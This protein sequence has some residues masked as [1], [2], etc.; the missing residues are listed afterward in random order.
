MRIELYGVHADNS[1]MRRDRTGRNEV[2]RRLIGSR[3]HGIST[4]ILALVVVAWSTIV[5]V[6]TP[7]SVAAAP[8]SRV[9]IAQVGGQ[10][11][12]GR[13]IVQFKSERGL[14]SRVA[15]ERTHGTEI[16][17]EWTS[18]L[19]GF[20]G[21]LSPAALTR[22]QS[23]PEV[24]RIEPDQVITTDTY[25]PSPPS[26]GLDRIDQ[27][28]LPLT[29]SY[30]YVSTGSGVTAY[31]VDTG[32]RSTHTEFTGRVGAGFVS[33]LFSPPLVGTEDCDGHGTHVAGTIGGTTYGVAKGVTLV[34]VRVLDCTG[35]GTSSTVIDGLNW[36]IL[37]HSP[38][39][40]A[41]ANMSLGG[42]ISSALDTAVNNVIADGVTVVVAAGN[43]SVPAMAGP[44]PTPAITALSCDYSPAR[45]PNAIT[46]GAT[47]SDDVIA[48]Y[49][50]RGSC[51]DVYAPG[52]S[53]V[54][55]WYL[56]DS[57]T[58]TLSG[59]SMATPHVVGAVARYLQD[60]PASTPAQVASALTSAATT[61]ALSATILVAGDPDKLLYV[62]A[63]PGPP[64]SVSGVPANA[65]VAVS[66]LAPLSDGVPIN[67]YVVEYKTVAAPTWTTFADG[68]S[69][70]TGAT[71]AGL[72]NG[73]P[74]VFRIT[75]LN[76]VGTGPVSSVSGSIAP[77]VTVPG[78]P[79]SVA[80]TIGN[81]Q[82]AVSWMAP[83]DNGGSAI[84]GYTVTSSATPVSRT[85]STGG[86]L[87]CIVSG[88]TNGSSY[89]FTVIAT[90]GLGTG[91]ASAASAGL[92]PATVPG[93]PTSVTG[94]PSHALV[95]VS[96][97]PPASNGGRL[98]T[99]YRVTASPGSFTCSTTGSTSCI[100]LGLTD[101]TSYSVVVSATNSIGSGGN[102]NASTLFTPIPT[103]PASPTGVTA[104][105]GNGQASVSWVPPAD[106]GGAP[107]TAY[108][109]VGN[110]GAV[111]CAPIDPT[112]CVVSG[113]SVSAAY[114]FTVVAINIVGS[115][116][117]SSPSSPVTPGYGFTPV[118]PVRVFDS[119]PGEA[120]GVVVVAKQRFGGGNVLR[121]KVTGVGGVP[122]SGV[123]AVSL[124]VTVVDPLAA[125]FVTVFPCG[126]L[127]VASS[128]NFVAGQTVPNAVIAPV[129]VGG[130][131]CLFS[132]VDT[133]LLADVNGW[134]EGA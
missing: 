90:N 51:N 89:T 77:V 99:G 129:S 75:A 71:V 86:A 98:I 124:N 125:G 59:T 102:S 62:A 79:T 123:G 54:S 27:R 81:T 48:A 34:P 60:N 2:P 110:G 31:V 134:F 133:F 24:L 107:I 61:G 56:S 14:H 74:Y 94:A 26:W 22:L 30:S 106:N 105:P 80:G 108:S 68:V 120:D 82:V 41:V 67:D 87:S 13:Y 5:G 37:D 38:G 100:V 11:I 64:R 55:A 113:L 23:D 6:S 121:V 12:P 16:D 57:A 49:S 95:T 18:A 43:D 17:D 53:I 10:T 101:G 103:A 8:S 1:T 4:T 9:A 109:V 32:I 35:N 104:V 70:S 46:V 93:A 69:G 83:A 91:A 116:S 36:I 47:G 131:V 76:S 52:S 19:D 29:S 15:A 130:E 92:S 78:S 97:T 63:P 126:A 44:P 115:S 85:C 128:L 3:T 66:W 122:G 111:I 21:T 65:R 58:K 28:P 114:T 7:L 132:S 119:R 73:I 72:V 88:L 40:P 127:P 39:V 50:N 84:T 117:P 33:T 42:G 45:V 96:W 118:V 112:S 25:Q 20:T